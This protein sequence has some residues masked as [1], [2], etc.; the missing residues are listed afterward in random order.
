MLVGLVISCLPQLLDNAEQPLVPPYQYHGSYLAPYFGQFSQPPGAEQAPAYQTV[1]TMLAQSTCTQAAIGNW[2]GLEYPLWVGLQH[3]HYGGVLNDFN[4]DNDTQKLEPSYRPSA[5]ITQQ[6]K[7]YVTPNNGTVNVQQSD[8]ALSIDANKAATIQTAIPRFQSTV[9]GVRVLPGGG[10]SMAR[11]GTLPF[12]VS[13]GSLY[14]FSNS[15]QPIQLLLHLVPTVPQSTVPPLRGQRAV[16]THD[17][18]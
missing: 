18:G 2:V 15:A 14:L 12:L 5:S 1:T 13:S 4:V 9:R 10:W 8:L 3:E 11:Y 7:Q 17:D 6:G 16:G